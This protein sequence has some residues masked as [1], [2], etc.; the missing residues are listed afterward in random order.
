MNTVKEILSAN[1]ESVI[2]SIKWAFKVWKNE[3]VKAKMIEFLAYAEE[4]LN[5][6]SYERIKAKK[7]YLK[8]LVMQMQAKQEK[9]SNL[10]KYGVENP[11][12][13][14][15]MSHSA[16]RNEDAGKVWNPINKCWE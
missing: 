9:A 10:I 4:K 15:I 11:K 7:S 2:S 12:L 5:V 3:D 16:M 1:R 6:E 13:A 14:D 8:Q